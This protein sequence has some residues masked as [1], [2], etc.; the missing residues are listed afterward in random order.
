MTFSDAFIL[1]YKMSEKV[2]VI[3]CDGKHFA[4]QNLDEKLFLK[5]G[6]KEE[7]RYKGYDF[8]SFIC[9]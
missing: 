1:K 5:V 4:F 7:K 8:I 9:I 6:M 2:W 3:F